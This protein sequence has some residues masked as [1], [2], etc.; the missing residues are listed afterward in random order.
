M[1]RFFILFLISVCFSSTSWVANDISGTWMNADKDAHIKIYGSYGKY[2]GQIVWM[3][4]P[5]DSITGKPQLD[6]LNKDPKLRSRP[7]MNMIII[8]GLEFDAGD[9]EWTDG[10]IYNPKG[11]DSYDLYCKMK[12][13]NTLEVHF[14]MTITTIGKTFFWTRVK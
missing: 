5:L 14:Y 7:V 4:E 6:K 10:T 1:I 11:G 2:Y 9:Q 3:K 12:D 8:S 13:K